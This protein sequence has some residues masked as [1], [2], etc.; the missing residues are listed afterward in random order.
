MSTQ[1]HTEGDAAKIYIITR[2]SE[3]EYVSAWRTPDAAQAEVERLTK[4]HGRFLFEWEEA[5][6]NG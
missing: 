3:G 6:L 1:Q 5:V 2:G 4:E